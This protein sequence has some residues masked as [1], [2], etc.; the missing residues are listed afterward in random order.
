MAPAFRFSEDE[1]RLCL[2]LLDV[3]SGVFTTAAKDS[4]TR[5]EVLIVLDLLR[6]DTDM[7][8]P[9]VVIA[10]QISTEEINMTCICCQLPDH[11]LGFIQWT[12]PS[13]GRVCSL[14]PS[15]TPDRS[16]SGEQA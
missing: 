5:D 16:T 6:S 12:C 8:D 11:Q 7:F 14:N 4:Y 13:C 2:G 1:Q 9:L 10:H 3:L 15:T